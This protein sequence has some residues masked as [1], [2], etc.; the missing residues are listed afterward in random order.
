MLNRKNSRGGGRGDGGSLSQP[1]NVTRTLQVA[2][3]VGERLRQA[4][5]QV[6]TAGTYTPLCKGA[7]C[8]RVLAPSQNAYTRTIVQLGSPRAFAML[9]MQ[10]R[11]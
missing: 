4:G 3:S 2:V 11:C 7:L 6:G 10:I 9:Q 1:P 5:W 8:V